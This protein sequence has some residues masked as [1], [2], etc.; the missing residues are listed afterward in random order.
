MSLLKYNVDLLEKAFV[1]Q[2]IGQDANLT[3]YVKTYGPFVSSNGWEVRVDNEP[4]IDVENK[5]VYLRGD[6]T[7]K[8]L[9]VDKNWNLSSN[10]SRDSIVRNVDYA[11]NE[12]ISSYKNRSYS[13]KPSFK[14][15]SGNPFAN[16]NKLNPKMINDQVLV[17]RIY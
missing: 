17:L 1:F 5:I 2:V 12:L 16:V 8:D 3:D 13:Y 11:L 4:E 7:S 10:Y 14:T 15:T 9:K 6:Q